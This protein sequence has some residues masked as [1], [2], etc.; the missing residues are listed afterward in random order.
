MFV[1]LPQVVVHGNHEHREEWLPNAEEILNHATVLTWEEA[2]FDVPQKE[3]GE[4]SEPIQVR[5]S[6]THCN[7][8]EMK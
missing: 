8:I 1:L 4:G 2:T 5:E 3:G 7:T 6:C